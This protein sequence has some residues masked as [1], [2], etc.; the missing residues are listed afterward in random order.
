[1]R[2]FVREVLTGRVLAL[3]AVWPECPRELDE[4]LSAATHPAWRERL[5]PRQ[6]RARLPRW[7]APRHDDNPIPTIV[8]ELAGADLR[9]R[10]AAWRIEAD[11][12]STEQVAARARFRK[13]EFRK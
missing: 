2:S 10:A 12:Q 9:K 3:R 7:L 13:V 8:E 11:L 1:E 4:L 6:L 5:S